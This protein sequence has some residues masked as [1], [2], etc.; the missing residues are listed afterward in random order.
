MRN[1]LFAVLAVLCVGCNPSGACENTREPPPSCVNVDQR[2]CEPMAASG[3]A[4]FHAG[5][6]CEALGFTNCSASGCRRP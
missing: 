5:T 6:T 2:S 3:H 1:T 4:V